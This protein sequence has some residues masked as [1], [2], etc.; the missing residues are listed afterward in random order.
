M[1][2]PT[3]VATAANATRKIDTNSSG[4]VTASCR[5]AMNSAPVTTGCFWQQGLERFDHGRGIESGL[6][7]D[8]H[9][10]EAALTEHIRRRL[11]IGEEGGARPGCC[12]RRAVPGDPGDRRVVETGCGQHLQTIA[13]RKTRFIGNGSINSDLPGRPRCCAL[14]DERRRAYRGW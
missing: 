11:G 4:V 10:G 5:S 9:S 2:M 12:V 13:D 6:Q 3:A 8:Q 1:L 7:L 14:S